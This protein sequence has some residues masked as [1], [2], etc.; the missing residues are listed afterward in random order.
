MR[1]LTFSCLFVLSLTIASTTAIAPLYAQQAAKHKPA[2]TSGLTNDDIIGLAGAGLSDDVIIAKIQKAPSTSFDTSVAGLKSLKAA[3]VSSAVI[4]VMLDP[5]AP[6]DAPAPPPLAPMPVA[7]AA[8]PIPSADDPTTVHSPGIYMMA[9]GADGQPH[10][11][12]LEHVVPKQT[13]ASGAFLSGLTYGITKA[14]IR[15]VIDGGKAS[16]EVGDNNPTFYAYIPEDNSTFGGSAISIKDFSLVKFDVNG[17]T[18]TVITGSGSIW[19][20]SA[21]TDQKALQGFT[22]DVI[23]PGIYKLTL[24]QPL[25]AGEYA[26]QQAGS[27]GSSSDQKNTGSYFDFGIIADAATSASK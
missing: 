7:A 11:A 12:K 16:L 25:P 20:V 24:A 4:K 3:G 5:T 1:R 13:K 19:G 8:P 27:S 10:L 18:R 22:S 9:K 17:E 23:K 14:K 2:A 21:G 26:F 6:V 15:V